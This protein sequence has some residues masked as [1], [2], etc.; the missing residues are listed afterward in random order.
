ML[1]VIIQTWLSCVYLSSYQNIR[2]FSPTVPRNPGPKALFGC[3]NQIVSKFI[4]YSQVRKDGVQIWMGFTHLARFVSCC[5]WLNGNPI[6]G[7]EDCCGNI[8]FMPI[9]N[10]SLYVSPLSSR[11]R[12]RS[13]MSLPNN[14]NFSDTGPSYDSGLNQYDS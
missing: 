9:F 4:S 8:C 10:L 13:E 2:N 12:K 11:S 7:A 1:R 14:C 5:H 3:C 6:T